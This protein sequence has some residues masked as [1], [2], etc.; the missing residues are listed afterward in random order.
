M[1]EKRLLPPL[2]KII[3]LKHHKNVLTGYVSGC[4][5]MFW[6]H[7]QKIC[8]KDIFYQKANCSHKEKGVCIYIYICL[9]FIINIHLC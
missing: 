6:E 4:F 2:K 5:I 9:H 3:I 8:K 7:N 1:K